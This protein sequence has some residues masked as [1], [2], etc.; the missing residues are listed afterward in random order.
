MIRDAWPLLPLDEWKATKDTLHMWTQIVGKVRMVKT[1]LVNHFWNVPLYVTPRGLTTS[2]IPDGRR[3][4][5]I[6]FDFLAHELVVVTSDGRSRSFALSPMAVADFYGEIMATLAAL[7]IEVKITTQPVETDIT[8]PFDR[9]REHDSYDRDAVERLHAILLQS[10]RVLQ[11]FRAEF[12]GKSSPVHFFWGSFDLAV[13]RFSG[14]RAPPREGADSIMRE[15]YSH[16]VYSVGWWPG[17]GAIDY[18]TY[19][20]YAVPQPPGFRDAKVGPAGAFY[21]GELNEFLL[22]YE[23]VRAAAKPES[24]LLEFARTGYEAA[25]EL[26]RWERDELERNRTSV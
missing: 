8:T 25:A 10:E 21:S 12:I 2:M 26:G 1:P 18:A 5:Q 22:P 17:S 23:V 11:T 7:G 20:A 15:G 14:R 6:D 19:Y 4:F 9:D 24:A 3:S 16:E 13:T